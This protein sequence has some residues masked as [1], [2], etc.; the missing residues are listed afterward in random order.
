M[1]LLFFQPFMLLGALLVGVPLLIYLFNRQLYKRRRWAAMEFLERAIQKN[2][3]RLRI[4]NLLLLL[5]RCAI[6][7]LLALAM[8]RPYMKSGALG[9]LSQGP[10]NW[11][12]ALDTSYSMNTSEGGRSLF[13]EARESISRM[14]QE[15]LEPG[16][17][18]AVLTFD[19]TPREVISPRTLTVENR[20]EILEEIEALRPGYR[21]VDVGSSLGLALDVA[22][23]FQ[24]IGGFET[25]LEAKKLVLFSDFQKSDWL[26]A[27][28][29]RDPAVAGL[30]GSLREAQVDLRLADLPARNRNLSVVDL[31][32]RPRVVSRDVWVEIVATVAN[33]GRDDFESAQ[34]VFLI[35]G[36]EERTHV[37]RVPA[38]SRV[39]RTLPYRFSEAGDHSIEVR[40]QGDDL[41]TDNHRFHVVNVLEAA[42]V[43]L[44][45]GEPGSSPLE[46]ET[47]LLE[48]ALL[49]E[50]GDGFKRTPYQPVVLPVE[51]LVDSSVD[52]ADHVAVILANVSVEDLPVEFIERL[53][54]HVREGGALIVAAG[55]NV[56]AT[57]YN[58]AFGPGPDSLLPFPL[59]GEVESPEESVSLVLSDPDHPVA[60]YFI[61]R[62]DNSY[63]GRGFIE[64]RRFLRMDPGEEE[65]PEGT[66]I[67]MRFEDEQGPP[68]LVE[69]RLGLGHVLW[70]NTSVDTEWNDFAKYPDFIP[71]IH[72]LLPHLKAGSGEGANLGLG[73]PIRKIFEAQDYAP[74]VKVL[75][76]PEVGLEG[77][78]ATAALTRNLQEIPGEDRFELLHEE[79]SRPGL[80]SVVLRRPQASTVQWTERELRFA[81]NLSPDEGDLESVTAAQL[82]EQFPD[83]TV[84]SF[85]PVEEI[86]ALTKSR[87]LVGGTEFWRPLLWCV[88]IFLLA[89]SVLALLFGRR[90]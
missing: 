58:E 44:V 7:L 54:R 29:P 64:V 79:T 28:G 43:L 40:I 18:L 80:Y 22:G 31:S 34:L 70:F 69:R 17:R 9:P 6:L 48:L 27:T 89:E 39:S 82:R 47:L 74:D 2:R 67:W 37:L 61:E 26:S 88:L 85:S 41:R 32:V 83:L 87:E 51:E 1:S 72:E 50:T 46:R 52:P 4:E 84:E 56:R 33:P 59:T 78:G 23:R 55:K 66:R 81:V 13:E 75:P 5:L 53:E 3:R 60:R 42:E 11:I 24:E 71:F 45:D 35:D 68:A 25:R 57:N 73:E 65:V 8:A 19:R 77:T 30:L 36:Q 12:F 86:S 62:E 76:P 49:P 90:Q 21:S 15:V 10:R 14:V 16:D 38:G 20:N 63:L